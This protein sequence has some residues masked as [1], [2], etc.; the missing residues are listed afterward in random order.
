MKGEVQTLYTVMQGQEGECA[1]VG[2][3]GECSQ[4]VLLSWPTWVPMWCLILSLTL[5]GLLSTIRLY[6]F[7]NGEGPHIY[8]GLLFN[9]LIQV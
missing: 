8:E 1:C 2:G 3:G 9:P 4:G 7:Q 6:Y 5:E